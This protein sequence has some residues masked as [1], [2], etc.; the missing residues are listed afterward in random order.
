MAKRRKSHFLTLL[1]TL[2]PMQCIFL[3][4][5]SLASYLT[6][7]WDPNTEPDLAGYRVY[8]GTESREYADSIDVGN[9]TTYQLDNLLDG[10]TYFIAVTAYDTSGNE[11]DLSHEVSGAGMTDSTNSGVTAIEIGSEDGVVDWGCFIA[12][13]AYGSLWEPH[14]RTLRD[15]RDH[16]LTKSQLG[17]SFV[18]DYYRYSPFIAQHIQ[19]NPSLKGATRMSLTPLVLLS[20][21]LVRSTMTDKIVYLLFV[22]CYSLC[23]FKW[24]LKNHPNI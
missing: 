2:I 15:F 22:L 1:L 3:P 13:V 10:V 7:A 11:S 12:T 24:L 17:K 5:S 20:Q 19:A 14:V 9:I 23:I 8:Y 21:M 6:L 18:R 4:G 16:Y